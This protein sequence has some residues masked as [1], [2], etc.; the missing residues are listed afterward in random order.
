MPLCECALTRDLEQKC[1]GR[2]TT[3]N[4]TDGRFFIVPDDK[5]FAFF[6]TSLAQ[7]MSRSLLATLLFFMCIVGFLLRESRHEMSH[8]IF[9]NYHRGHGRIVLAAASFAT[10]VLCIL[11]G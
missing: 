1:V 10:T 5:N 8:G 3:T 6:E 2:T 11:Q 7:E 4:N 9:I